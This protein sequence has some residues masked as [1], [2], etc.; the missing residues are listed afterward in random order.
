VRL[1]PLALAG[2]QVAQRVHGLV[3]LH[4]LHQPCGV[5]GFGLA[6]QVLQ[7][8]RFHLLQGVR[9]G[10]RFQHVQQQLPLGP[11]EVHQQVGQVSRA[12]PVQRA[13]G[14]TQLER[15]CP[16]S[17]RVLLGG[18]DVSLPTLLR[19]L[20]PRRCQSSTRSG[21]GRA[22]Q[23]RGP[24]RRSKVGRLTSTPPSRTRSDRGQFLSDHRADQM[25]MAAMWSP[26]R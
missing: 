13:P 5:A 6:Q 22:C 19:R 10:S 24:R 21:V 25:K 17:D 16:L 3:R 9:C 2:V 11:A 18:V 7:L 8:G 1:Q 23:R 20:G 12:Q 26:A 4:L 15:N 14:G